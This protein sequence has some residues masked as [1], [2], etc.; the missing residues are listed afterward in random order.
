MPLMA[1]YTLVRN[2]IRC[3]IESAAS[4]LKKTKYI[5]DIGA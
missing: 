4:Y 3:A 2:G 5:L 1:I